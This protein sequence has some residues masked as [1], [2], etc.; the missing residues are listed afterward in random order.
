MNVI[1]NVCFLEENERQ[2]EDKCNISH[3]RPNLRNHNTNGIFISLS[4]VGK[5]LNSD[6]VYDILR[7][8]KYR[9]IMTFNIGKRLREGEY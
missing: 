6:K 7:K 5:V 3:I 4:E 9:S 1:A 8:L 2:E